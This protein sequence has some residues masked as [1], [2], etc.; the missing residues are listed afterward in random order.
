MP[1]GRV[2]VISVVTIWTLL[3]ALGGR[4]FMD[5]TSVAVLA[6]TVHI[7]NKPWEAASLV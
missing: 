3:S 5:L 6:F 4:R 1:W 2:S 7:A